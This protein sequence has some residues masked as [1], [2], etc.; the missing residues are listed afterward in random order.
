MFVYCHFLIAFTVKSIKI[1]TISCTINVTVNMTTIDIYFC[2]FTF[3][4]GKLA[5][6]I[7]TDVYIT[8]NIITSVNVAMNI[9][10]GII[11]GICAIFTDV[12]IG[13]V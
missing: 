10:I 3:E 11:V 4:V 12:N 8:G 13:C 2:S 1:V 9:D 5:S 6:F 7:K